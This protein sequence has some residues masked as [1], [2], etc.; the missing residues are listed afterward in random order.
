MQAG[1]VL[2]ILMG[3]VFLLT[4]MLEYSRIG[5]APPTGRSGR[6]SSASP[7]CTARMSSSG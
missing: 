7:A 4:Q 2:T 5:F 6:S 1:L 3:F